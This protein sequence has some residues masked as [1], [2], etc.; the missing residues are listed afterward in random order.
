MHLMCV[1]VTY[2]LGYQ[3]RYLLFLFLQQLEPPVGASLLFFWQ[4]LNPS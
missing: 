2:W 3:K 1:S 4:T